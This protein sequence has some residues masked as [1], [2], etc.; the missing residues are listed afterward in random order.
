MVMGPAACSVT[1]VW[2][3]PV[4]LASGKEDGAVDLAVV[5]DDAGAVG[6]G[7]VDFSVVEGAGCVGA[8]AAVVG[9]TVVTVRAGS[10]GAGAAL[11]GDATGSWRRRRALSDE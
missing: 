3:Q 5:E 6:A 8:A 1:P 9:A 4:V 11:V 10:L 7:L 2:R